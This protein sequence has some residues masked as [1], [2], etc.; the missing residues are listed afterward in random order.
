MPITRRGFLV[1][2]GATAAG[3]TLGAC[4]SNSSS[5]SSGTSATTA[6][7][8]ARTIAPTTTKPVPLRRAGERPDPTRPE[9]TDLLPQIEHVVVVMMENHSYDNYLGVLRRGDGFVLGT[10]GNPTATCL[11][12]AGHPVRAFHMPN[13]CQLPKKPSQAWNAT[14]AQWNHGKM[15]GFVRSDS[16]PVAMG[17]WTAADLP[18]YHALAST[19]PLCDRWF[20][21]CMGQTYPNRRYLLAGTSRGN[22]ATNA[23]GI[24]GFQPPNGTIMDALNKHHVPWRNYFTDL[25]TTGLFGP[26]INRSPG[27]VVPI[28]DYFADAAAGRLPAF[29]L[30]DPNFDHASEENSDDISTGESFVAKVVDAALRGPGWSKTVLIWLYDEHGGYY[31]HVPPP[32]A[33]PPDAVPPQLKAGDTAGRFDVYGFRVPAVIVSPFARKDYVSHVVHDHTSILKLVETKFN[34]PALTDRDANAD[35][36]LDSLDLHGTPAFAIAPALPPPK[37]PSITTPLCTAPGPVPTATS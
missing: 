31:D 25:P 7:S 8:T 28:A 36:L 9:G 6:P 33:V 29:S 11:D 30:V 2:A 13:T 23:E 24:T 35:G 10:D 26:V 34:L 16:G 12:A 27:S 32:A 17:Y 5:S 4:S 37:N 21:S 14:H 19:F 15:D 18:F 1:G 22:V 20:G 3:L